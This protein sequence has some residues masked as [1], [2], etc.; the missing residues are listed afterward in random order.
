MAQSS[1]SIESRVASTVLESHP[2]EVEVM[3][4]ADNSTSVELLEGDGKSVGTVRLWKYALPGHPADE[5]FTV[6]ETIAKMD[7]ENRSLTLNVLEGCVLKTYEGFIV[8]VSVTPKEGAEDSEC[9]VRWILDLEKEHEDVP[10]P[11]LYMEL[12][13]FIS[14]ELGSLLPN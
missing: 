9:I 7:D 3:C 8:T 2:V 1:E 4:S 12:V 14:K 6:K 5:I 11:H 10:H 13:D